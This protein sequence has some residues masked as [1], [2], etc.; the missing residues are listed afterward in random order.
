MSAARTN[1]P[2]SIA[3]SSGKGG[4][5]KTIIAMTLARIL[6]HCGFQ[7]ILVDADAATGGMSYFLR[8]RKTASSVLSAG[9]TEI[10]KAHYKGQ[11]IVSEVVQAIKPVEGFRN[12]SFL[13]VGRHQDFYDSIALGM[14]RYTYEDLLNILRQKYQWII[15]DC[16]GGIDMD[17]M[18][19]YAV[20]DEILLVVETDTTSKQATGQLIAYLESQ[21]LG[22]KIRGYMYN[23][24]LSPSYIFLD[25]DK[26]ILGKIACLTSISFDVQ[27]G[28]D[29]QEC[30]IPEPQSQFGTQIWK[31]LYEAYH[32]QEPEKKP[33]ENEDLP[34]VKV[35]THDSDTGGTVVAF[36][37]L[38]L[39]ISVFLDILSLPPKVSAIIFSALLL[40]VLGGFENI[41]QPI[42]VAVT[43]GIRSVTKLI[44]PKGP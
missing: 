26:K 17:A 16:R 22:N 24:V 19:L 2:L 41:R 28:T 38:A 33:R 10:A 18:A 8:M 9:L 15:V 44:S 6:G 5:G 27:A 25:Y 36:L 21:R 23:K 40:G 7:T 34:E 12:L 3:V 31:A 30:R 39:T 42:G 32:V 4:S 20:V 37:I 35:T 43:R 14:L 13:G 1:H 29:F 11:P